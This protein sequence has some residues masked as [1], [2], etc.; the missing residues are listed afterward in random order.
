M[1]ADA[2]ALQNTGSE[3][4]QRVLCTSPFPA[5]S[6]PL[7]VLQLHLAPHSLVLTRHHRKDE[8]TVMDL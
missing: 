1:A 6:V 3:A 8:H 7:M 4:V 5:P 2:G